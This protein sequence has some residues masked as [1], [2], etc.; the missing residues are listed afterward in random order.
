MT[1]TLA[2]RAGVITLIA[3][4]AAATLTGCAGVIGAR[5]TFDDTE[6]TKITE[7]R[8]DGGAGNV[9]IR[10]ADVTETNI[11]RIIRRST[12]D[13]GESYRLD[14]SKLLIDSSC[15]H[16]CFV[17]YEIVAP[18]GVKVSG[19][20]RSGDISLEAVGDTD[21]KMTS[22]D[23]NVMDPAGKVKIRAGSGDMRVM[24][25]K[26]AVDIQ[27][28]SG[29]IN[30]IDSAGPLTLKVT[31]GDI[32]AGLSAP[33]SVT[34]QTTSGDVQVRVPTGSYRI[35]TRT[36]SG[37]ANVSGLVSDPDAKNVLNLR[38]AS[39]DAMVSAA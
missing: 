23:V 9:A 19:E 21:V 29:D 27:S 34:A 15:G 24:N 25:A 26:S 30:V 22:G 35:E 37:D 32:S 8:L 28:T 36:G 6:K 1:A 7:I 5:M 16:D 39:G 10:T 12:S 3:A 14:G 13:P 4:T 33:A 11:K 20:F 18:A 31:S 38:T 2:R 17:S